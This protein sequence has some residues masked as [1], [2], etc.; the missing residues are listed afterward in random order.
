MLQPLH[1]EAWLIDK[2]I[3][4]S[5][6]TCYNYNSCRLYADSSYIINCKHALHVSTYDNF[7]HFAVSV[8]PQKSAVYISVSV[9]VNHT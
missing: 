7:F 6:N 1:L 5:Y 2:Q 4:S 8:V 3:Y 9:S